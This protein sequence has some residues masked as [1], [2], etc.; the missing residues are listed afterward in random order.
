[1]PTPNTVSCSKLLVTV[2]AFVSATMTDSQV[3]YA[4]G[5]AH[6]HVS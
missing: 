3:V 2:F 4:P 1:M 5:L 6:L